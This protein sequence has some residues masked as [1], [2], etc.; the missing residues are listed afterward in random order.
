VDVPENKMMVC[1][2]CHL[3]IHDKLQRVPENLW[4]AANLAYKEWLESKKLKKADGIS[5]PRLSIESVSYKRPSEEEIVE[6]SRRY[7]E[8]LKQ[9]QKKYREEI[10]IRWEKK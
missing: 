2:E 10:R 4:K 5:S 3:K 7:K 8:I 1:Y 9:K 6:R